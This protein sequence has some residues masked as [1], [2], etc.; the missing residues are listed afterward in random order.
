MADRPKLSVVREPAPAASIAT[1]R[2]AT[3]KPL[4]M[5]MFDALVGGTTPD[6]R[7]LERQLAMLERESVRS[8]KSADVERRLKEQNRKLKP[9]ERLNRED[10][11]G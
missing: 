3:T 11:H 1:G 9:P 4:V 7:E 10:D 6:R 2:T 5:A 8:G